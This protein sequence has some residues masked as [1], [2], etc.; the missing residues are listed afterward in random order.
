MLITCLSVSA[1]S[2]IC[3]FMKSMSNTDTEVSIDGQ[4]V[5]GLNGTV[6]RT[7]NPGF[8]LILP[9]ET[10]EACYRKIIINKEEKVIVS[11]SFVYTNASNGN[12]TTY[13]AE[14]PLDLEDGETYYLQVVAKGLNDTQIK[15][16]KEKDVKKWLKKWEELSSV[17]L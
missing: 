15:E 5:C 7:I 3:M 10:R 4:I 9:F 13:K 2:T 11:V 16:P 6:K 14:Y 12:K 17:T 1:E 8:G